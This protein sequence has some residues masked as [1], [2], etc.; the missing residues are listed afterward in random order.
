MGQVRSEVEY[1]RQVKQVYLVQI[2]QA[3]HQRFVPIEEGCDV[4]GYVEIY[5]VT[6]TKSAWKM[7]HGVEET[8]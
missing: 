4:I 6:G 8:L 5:S 7:R 3:V 2:Q 1:I